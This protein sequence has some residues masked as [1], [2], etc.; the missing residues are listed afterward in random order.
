M[1]LR[2]SSDYKLYF[3]LQRD[4]IATSVIDWLGDH[5]IE[6]VILVYGCAL[7]IC[8]GLFV[9]SALDQR[10]KMLLLAL[11]ELEGLE[12]D[13]DFLDFTGDVNV[14]ADS[15]VPLIP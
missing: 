9:Q 5:H 15:R 12:I 14:L 3:S 11:K 13:E 10:L 1:R 7:V 6:L 8:T 4:S 2:S